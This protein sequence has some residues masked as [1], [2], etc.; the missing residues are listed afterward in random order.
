M[1]HDI[2]GQPI[3]EGDRVALPLGFGMLG[4]GQ[5]VAVSSGL[6]LPGAPNQPTTPQVTVAVQIQLNVQPDGTV[7]GI[8]KVGGGPERK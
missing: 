6:V 2:I 1:L 8:T 3:Q 5:I 7:G 4:V